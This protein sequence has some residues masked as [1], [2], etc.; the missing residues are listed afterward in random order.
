MVRKVELNDPV[1]PGVL[2]VDPGDKIRVNVEFWYRGPAYRETLYAALY[3]GTWPGPI[4]EVSGGAGAKGWDI[5]AAADWV[6]VRG[7]YVIVP[8]PGR[9]GETFGLYAKLG[10]WPP[11]GYDNVIEVAGIPPAPEVKNL[12]ITS[13]IKA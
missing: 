6:I 5:A 1:P 3:K 8:V 7:L 9:P 4:D 12:K 2:A 11:D 10:G 13:Y